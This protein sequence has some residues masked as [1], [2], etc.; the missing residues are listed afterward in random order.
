MQFRACGKVA[1]DGANG[2]AW[3]LSLVLLT[4]YLVAWPAGHVI[5][6]NMLCCPCWLSQT[7]AVS[8]IRGTFRVQVA[9]DARSLQGAS[10]ATGLQVRHIIE[11]LHTHNQAL[12][13]TLNQNMV[14]NPCNSVWAELK[15][16]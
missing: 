1:E 2:H 9:E 14:D 15:E 13:Y 3:P 16:F 12:E 7:H 4:K 6:Y 11:V 8:G 5:A 10:T